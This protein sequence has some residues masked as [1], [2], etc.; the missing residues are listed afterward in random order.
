MTDV[1]IETHLANDD[2]SDFIGD[3]ALGVAFGVLVATGTDH[4]A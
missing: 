4:G 3:V 1:R 2:D